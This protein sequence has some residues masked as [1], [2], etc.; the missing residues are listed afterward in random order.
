[1][2]NTSQSETLVSL[3]ECVLGQ[4][5]AVNVP[6]TLT[7]LPVRCGAAGIADAVKPKLQELD[8]KLLG[9]MLY[10]YSISQHISTP[11]LLEAA[12]PLIPKLVPAM[13]PVALASLARTY[14]RVGSF[15]T[16]SVLAALS[17]A[18]ADKLEQFT[19]RGKELCNGE[20]QPIDFC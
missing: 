9:L 10:S 6:E 12:A 1:M 11:T 13:P 7:L 17:E 8:Q 20:G 5:D 14:H 18:A 4:V 3:H 2:H 15:D 19:T 16:S